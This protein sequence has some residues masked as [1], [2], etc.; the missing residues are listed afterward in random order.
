MK[1]L[2]V[3]SKSKRADKLLSKKKEA[4]LVRA[5][6][7]ALNFQTKQQIITSPTDGY[8]ENF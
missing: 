6:T 1:Y 7:N 2:K 4:S 8:I 3:L 5:E